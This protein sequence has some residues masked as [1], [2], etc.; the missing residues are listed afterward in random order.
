MAFY[1]GCRQHM[2]RNH[3]PHAHRSQPAAL[4]QCAS[5]FRQ[6]ASAV[7]QAEGPDGDSASE[8][9]SPHA[10]GARMKRPCSRG[11]GSGSS[12]AQPMRRSSMPAGI[13]KNKLGEQPFLPAACSL[14]VFGQQRLSMLHNIRF[15]CCFATLP[16]SGQS[17]AQTMCASMDADCGLCRGLTYA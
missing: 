6:P 12:S 15:S 11:A 8:G 5:Q 7:L 10:E 3:K 17:L 16:S 14:P 9:A 2:Q 1:P 13:C 4:I